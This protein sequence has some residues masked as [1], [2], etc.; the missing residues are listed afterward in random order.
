M[1]IPDKY[2]QS[3]EGGNP[4]AQYHIGEC[5]CH[6]HDIQK[7]L[8]QAIYWLN[9]AAEQGF[10][11]ALNLLG[12]IYNSGEGVPQNLQLAFELYARAAKQ[13]DSEGQKNLGIMYEEGCGTEKDLQKALESYLKAANQ[14]H[15]EAMMIL[16]DIYFEG[17][18]DIPKVF[19]KAGRWYRA[20]A[21]KRYSP[22]LIKLGRLHLINAQELLEKDRA[23]RLPIQNEYREAVNCFKAAG[24]S[25]VFWIGFLTFTG[26]AVGLDKERGISLIIQAANS[27]DGSAQEYL[28]ERYFLGDGVPQDLENAKHWSKLAAS[29]GNSIAAANLA[30][31]SD[32]YWENL[33]AETILW[34]KSWGNNC[35]AAIEWHKQEYWRKYPRDSSLWHKSELWKDVCGE[36][37]IAWHQHFGQKPITAYCWFK[38]DYWKD[39]ISIAEAWSKYF[40]RDAATTEIWHKVP[41]WAG[42]Q[43]KIVCDWR[44]AWGED[45]ATAAEWHAIKE[46][47]DIPVRAYEWHTAPTW[48][49][50][51][52]KTIT[53]WRIEFG[54]DCEKAGLWYAEPYWR[55]KIVWAEYYCYKFPQKLTP[56]TAKE[57]HILHPNGPGSLGGYDRWRD[58][59]TGGW[60]Q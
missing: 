57:H 15:P 22:A 48:K 19:A 26:E 1:T 39:R 13:G 4:E 59:D 27:G 41:H 53:K 14:G 32:S 49:G 60:N 52:T 11:K 58:S 31:F 29:Q 55:D 33:G 40:K 10:P 8:K 35:Q 34:R 12:D 18:A 30:W 23:R 16:G 38:L 3:A 36:D 47:E 7:D 9:R 42:T 54:A 45:A 6:G 2:F 46:W 37:V 21:D 50:V 24:K 28:G 56:L 20:A 25:G 43:A 44:K 5:Y 51:D 17:S